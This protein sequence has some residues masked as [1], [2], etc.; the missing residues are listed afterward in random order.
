MQEF[1]NY[2][3]DFVRV[4]STYPAQRRQRRLSYSAMH[5]LEKT[6]DKAN[7]LRPQ[8]LKAP[9]TKERLRL[10]LEKFDEHEES[11]WGEFQ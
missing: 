9:S 4:S 2:T 1:Q 8:L 10:V 11:R 5:L 3:H 6:A 7:R